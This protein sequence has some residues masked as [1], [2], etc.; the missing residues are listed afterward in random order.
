[1]LGSIGSNINDQFPWI[2]LLILMLTAFGLIA[3]ATRITQK[4]SL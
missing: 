1:L 3:T 2:G 4:Q